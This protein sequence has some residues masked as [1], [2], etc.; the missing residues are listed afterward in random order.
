MRVCRAFHKLPDEIRRV[1]MED[2]VHMIES[3]GE[4]PYIDEAFFYS[5][6]SAKNKSVNAATK[7]SLAS[8][9]ARKKYLDKLNN[10]N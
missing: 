10:K 9:Q 3:L 2:Y 7:V 6:C 5:F 8:P 1:E 4:V